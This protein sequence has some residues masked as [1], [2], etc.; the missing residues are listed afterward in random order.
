MVQKWR[1]E[2]RLL[3]NFTLI[4]KLGKPRKLLLTG[5]YERSEGCEDKWKENGVVRLI[6]KKRGGGQEIERE[7]GKDRKRKKC[8]EE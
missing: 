6:E 2:V 4:K 7:R 8:G 1:A 3:V 5:I